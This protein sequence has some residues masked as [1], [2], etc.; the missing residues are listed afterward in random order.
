MAVYKQIALLLIIACSVSA[1]PARRKPFDIELENFFFKRNRSD[2]GAFVSARASWDY[3][4]VNDWSTSFPD[5]GG[6]S[7]SPIDI[8]TNDLVDGGFNFLRFARYIAQQ[9]MGMTNN[10]H[11]VV[12]YPIY[13]NDVER[14][15]LTPF[16]RRG[17][18]GAK[19]DFHSLH[20]HWGADSTKGSEHTINS[21]MF[22]AE[23]HLVHYNTRYGSLADAVTH[24]DGLAVIGVMIEAGDWDNSAFQP[25][26][27]K[28]S[29]VSSEGDE[30]EISGVSLA[31]LMPADKT[32][33]RFFR[34]SGS[35]TTP[36]CNEVVTWTVLEKTVSIS[37]QQ[38]ILPL[39]YG[40]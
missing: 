32:L 22:P 27:E 17:N 38:V 18:L 36:S 29:S 11:T 3:T 19:Y 23:M 40:T 39:S 16:I 37:E 13:S 5:C 4:G 33:S 2:A 14:L 31:Q 10:G 9:K 26:V 15:L 20:F 30:V 35:L 34:Y 7:Q 6:S 24:P 21:K 25:I 12:L 1:N 8:V 28:L